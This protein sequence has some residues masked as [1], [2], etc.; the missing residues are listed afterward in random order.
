[1]PDS[2][3]DLM[4]TLSATR[5]QLNECLIFYKNV[6]R[7]LAEAERL[8]KIAYRKE[9]FRL[10]IEDGVAWTACEGLAKGDETVAKLRMERDIRKSDY[11]S[12]YEKIL[13]LKAELRIIENEISFERRGM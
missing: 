2:G 8:Y 12:T 11:D 5:R 13:A 6:G 10:H 4:Q 3:Q 7:K 1:M 9:V